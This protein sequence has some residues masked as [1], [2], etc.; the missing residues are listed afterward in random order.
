[1]NNQLSSRYH[2]SDGESLIDTAGSRRGA[3]EAGCRLA[4]RTKAPATVFDTM[5]R[6][7]QPELWTIQPGTEL[8]RVI[9]P[10]RVRS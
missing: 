2:I 1:M 7:G 4:T 3:F 10:T 5:A 9:P 6:R 8:A